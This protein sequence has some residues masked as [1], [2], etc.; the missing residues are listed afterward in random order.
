MIC[1]QDI[2]KH[3][4]ILGSCWKIGSMNSRGL[5]SKKKR[6]EIQEAKDT[7][8]QA[9]WKKFLSIIMNKGSY[10][11][12]AYSAGSQN[13]RSRLKHHDSRKTVSRHSGVWEIEVTNYPVGLSIKNSLERQLQNG[14]N[15]KYVQ[16]INQFKNKVAVNLRNKSCTWRI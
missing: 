16:T 3:V 8:L 1:N 9:W 5:L 15:L 11:R 13:A 7:T 12:L 4:P 10:G 6:H 2:F 14:R